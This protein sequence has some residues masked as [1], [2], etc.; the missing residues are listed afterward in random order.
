MTAVSLRD[1]RTQ[2]AAGRYDL[3]CNLPGHYAAGMRVLLTVS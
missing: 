1:G 3:V 2:V